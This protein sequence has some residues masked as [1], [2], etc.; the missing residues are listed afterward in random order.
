[1]KGNYYTGTCIVQCKYSLQDF[2][3]NCKER[4]LAEHLQL[5]RPAAAGEDK[6]SA[7]ER[8]RR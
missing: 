1:M 3:L 4:K 5:S 6:L 2:L 8:A 7:A